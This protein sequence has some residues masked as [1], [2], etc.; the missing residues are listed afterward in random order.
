MKNIFTLLALLL[1]V[2]F[3]NLQEVNAQPAANNNTVLILD[4]TVTSGINSV[5]AQ[6][7][8]TAGF[9]VEIVTDA[10][11][12]AKSQADFATYRAI[13]LGDP[14]CQVGNAAID[15]AEN[16][17][18]TWSP[19]IDG[20][21]VIV[22]S[23][24]VFHQFQG[25]ATLVQKTI[26]FVLS[27]DP[28]K[29]KTGAYICLSCYYSSTCLPTSVT[30]LSAL[31]AAGADFKVI[32]DCVLS[33]YNDVHIT[34]T[35]PAL[36]GLTD[37]TISNWF[38]SLHEAFT[39]WDSLNYQVLAIA[40]DIAVNYI[41]PDGTSGIPYILARGARVISDITLGP[42][43]ATNIIGTNHTLTAT[44]DSNGTPVVGR[45]V[46]FTAIGGP[47]SG[48]LGSSVTNGA[49]VASLTYTCNSTGIQFIKATATI[50]GLGQTSNT[51]RKTWIDNP[52]P[53]E[54][55]ALTSTVSGRD[56]TINWTTITETNN[57]GFDIERSANGEW[58][59]VGNV[60]GHGNTTAS[61]N[62][63]FNDRNVASG[64]YNYRLKQIDFNGNFE[65]FNLSNEVNVGA[66]DNFSLRQN[67]PNPFNPSTKI[68][69][70]LPKDG[71]VSLSVYDN[72]GKEVASLINENR[73]AG[74]YT[75]DFNAAGLASGV[76]FY[77]LDVRSGDQSFVKVLK[78]SLLK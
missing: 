73:A 61:E 10:Q 29:T 36:T 74:Y 68:E 16:N 53:V 66:P 23:D 51:V 18:T 12:A 58:T 54:L 72:S 32:G 65:Y 39:E 13:I 28:G 34:A 59:K 52:L 57:A 76:Y 60:T 37:A 2:C 56:V 33:C 30:V 15:A 64:R 70:A 50:N 69:F 25:G 8:I 17:R 11:W 21:V 19:E 75:V 63:S 7:C 6:A 40:K 3:I 45:S 24:P 38:C 31:A 41:A 20:N 43:T 44:L 62:Y 55:S 27:D 1:T 78:M 48:V 4:E 47:C 67:Y 42:D 9:S 35:H 26:N 71:N 22:G 77:K 49:G 14:T 46:T 5:E